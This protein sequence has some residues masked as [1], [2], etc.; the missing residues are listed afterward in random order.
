V[1]GLTV[2]PVDNFAHIGGFAAGLVLGYGL[3]PRYR[4][5]EAISPHRITDRASLLRRWWVPTLGALVFGGGL[6]LA[7]DFWGSGGVS[8]P[9]V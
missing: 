8:L 2:M 4:V 9:F 3:T 6:W 1:L 5:D 7:L